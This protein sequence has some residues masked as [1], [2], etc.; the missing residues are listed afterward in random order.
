MS[1]VKILDISY[2][3]DN[4]D[5]PIKV[6][7]E[8]MR[9]SGVDGVIFRIGQNTWEDLKFKEYWENSSGKGF[10][11]GGYWYYDNRISPEIQAEKCVSIIKKYDANFE[12]PLFADF[13]DRRVGSSFPYMGWNNWYRFLTKLEILLPDFELGLYTGYYYFLENCPKTQPQRDYFG[14]Y[15]LW[16]AQYPYES[17]VAEELYTQ[18]KIPANTWGNWQVWQV[19]DRGNGHFHGVE[20]SRVD[21]NY[22]NGT[23]EEL[24]AKYGKPE[25]IIPSPEIPEPEIPEKESRS[26]TIDYGDKKVSYKEKV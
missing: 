10:L 11:R 16:I 5:T 19:S 17:H 9:N 23:L 2:Y 13:E 25:E 3:Q 20:S 24:Y 8:T 15:P 4:P 1:K 26:L 7:F 22:F 14:K 6:D 12:L 18:P 21:I